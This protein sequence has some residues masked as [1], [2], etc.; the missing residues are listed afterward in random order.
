[1][2]KILNSKDIEEI[3]NSLSL[4]P[5]S[6]NNKNFIISGAF[7]FIGKYILE[8]LLDYKNK[9]DYS[10]QYYLSPSPTHA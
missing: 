10:V 3:T 4:E 7:G 6:L 1:M 2:M 9:N 5:H 8:C